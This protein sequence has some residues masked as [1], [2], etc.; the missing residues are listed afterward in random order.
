MEQHSIERL[1]D[2]ADEISQKVG[3]KRHK[4][5]KQ[6]RNNMK[7]R[8]LIKEFYIQLIVYSEE[9][10]KL[11]K[12]NYQ[13]NNTRNSMKCPNIMNNNHTIKPHIKV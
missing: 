6:E 9:Q 12:G 3:N 5:G 10:R 11:R 13:R 7:L 4:F 8:G 1:E 2:E